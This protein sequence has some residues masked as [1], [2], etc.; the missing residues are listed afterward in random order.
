M[1]GWDQAPSLQIITS[2]EFFFRFCVS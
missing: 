1:G 2:K